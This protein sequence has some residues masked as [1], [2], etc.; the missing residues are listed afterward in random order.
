MIGLTLIFPLAPAKT[1]NLVSD[2]LFS[3]LTKMSIEGCLQIFQN[4]ESFL[5]EII[6]QLIKKM[7]LVKLLP[8]QTAGYQIPKIVAV[9]FAYQEVMFCISAAEVN[10]GQAFFAFYWR[11]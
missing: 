5:F 1:R 7:S 6:L 9:F 2:L 4:V 3:A 10:S 11:Q 8:D